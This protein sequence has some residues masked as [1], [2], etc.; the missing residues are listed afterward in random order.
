[1]SDQ[2]PHLDDR[3]VGI[4]RRAVLRRS[5]LGAAGLGA[6]A[7]ASWAPVRA[8]S[9][10]AQG[11]HGATANQQAAEPTMLPALPVTAPEISLHPAGMPR[12]ADYARYVDG[13]YLDLVERTGPMNHEI[14][15]T[16]REVVAEVMPGTTMNMWTFDGRIPGPMIRVRA[17]DTVDFFL[18]NDAAST[19]PH[20]VDFH[21][22]TGPGGGALRLDTLPGNESH[23][24]FRLLS[25]GIYI[26]HCAFPDVAMHISMG[27]YGLIVVEPEGGLP[28]VDHEFYVMQHEFYT[29]RGGSLPAASLAGAG[30]LPY[31]EAHGNEERPTFV[32]FNG[33]PGAVTGER[34][35]GKMGPP[36]NV[37]E[38]VRLF[39]GNIGPNLISSFHIIGEI[40]DTVYVEGS[41]DLVN[42]NVQSTTI[43]C[44]GAVGV[45]FRVEVPGTYLLVDHSIFRT[46]KGA[47]GE[48][49][50]GGEAE[51][52][53]F[54][55]I[56]SDLL[57]TTE[58]H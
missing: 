33:R 55:P 38:T 53:V 19:M 47:A 39:V 57:R 29:N 9:G 54:E 30:H 27:M 16:S 51:P 46:H 24:R 56:K 35:I 7:V 25:P 3:Q 32:M 22:V 8:A 49:V 18:A 14:R 12:S 50:V 15:V 5:F 6:A 26:Y 41:F 11:A 17:G 28:P 23:L 13:E 20:N 42:R 45:E 31:S 4:S 36:I 10:P 58:S 48:L 2:P 52:G 21:A 34:A 44:G 40:F 37:G 1:M 43:P